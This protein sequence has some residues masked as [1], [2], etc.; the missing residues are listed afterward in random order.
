MGVLDGL[1]YDP[2]SRISRWPPGTRM[3]YCSSGPAV[4]AYIVEKI[5]G[6]RFEDFVEHNLFQPIGMNTATYFQPTAEAAT[7]L[8]HDDGKTPYPYWNQIQRPEGSI[9]ASANDMARYVQFYLNRGAANGRQ[10]VPASDISRMESPT[11]TW[12]AEEGMKA[13][14]GLSNYWLVED[15]FVYHGHDGA[16]P[17]G[18]TNVGYMPD[19]G[20]GYF[21]S[22][23]SGNPQAFE[24][25]DKAIRAYITNKLQRPPVPTV[26]PLPS[27]AQE[28][29]GWYEPDSPRF[30]MLHFLERLALLS[31]IHFRDGK[32]TFTFLGGNRTFVPVAGTQFRL[33]PQKDPPDPVA[34]LELLTP[35]PE[36]RFV[37]AGIQTTMKRIPS[38]LAISEIAAT[39]FVALSIL[40]ILIYAPFWILGGLIR[41]RRRPAERAMRI[42]PLVAVLSLGAFVAVIILSSEDLIQR[43]G[44]LT[45]WSAAVFLATI[46]F[47]IAT[48]ASAIACWR[49]RTGTVRKGVRRFSMMVSAALLIAVVYLAYWNVIGLRTWS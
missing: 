32:L 23:N 30:E 40:A 47:A 33:I 3:A 1:N 35:N 18:Y 31:W 28:F 13:G 24:R 36:G 19:Y 20:V 21:F 42:W 9:N 26:A 46:V 2:H 25:I 11:S 38:W 44:N 6:Q 29:A 45:V 41:K 48:V 39:V 16:V 12:A 49:A 37:Q 15:G 27:N 17:G 5:T 10:I 22:I 8:Y 34:T 14:Y 43:M 7:T 4:A